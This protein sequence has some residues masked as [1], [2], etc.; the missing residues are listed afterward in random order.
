MLFLSIRNSMTNKITDVGEFIPLAAKHTYSGETQFKTTGDTPPANEPPK[1]VTLK[2]VWPEPNWLDL[3]S[4]GLDKDT[5]AQIYS[6]YHSLAKKPHKTERYSFSG[7]RITNEMWE[8]AFIEAVVFIREGCE[9]ATSS[10]DMADLLDTF[11]EHFTDDDGKRSYKTFAAGTKTAKTFLHPLGKSGSA[12]QYRK[13]LPYLD[14]PE[15]VNPKKIK[16][17]PIKLIDRTTKEETYSLCKV[18]KKS[19]SYGSTCGEYQNEF[20]SYQDA[21]NALVRYHGEEF[22][23]GSI[24]PDVPDEPLYIPKKPLSDLIPVDDTNEDVDP[25]TLMEQFGFRGI[26]FGNCLSGIEKQQFVNNT[27]FSLSVM[28]DVLDISDRWIGGGKLG[29]AFASRGRGNASAHYEPALHVINL[30]R[31]NGPGCIAHEFWHSLDQRLA[32]KWLGFEEVLLSAT[33]SDLYFSPARIPDQ[34]RVQFNAFLEIMEAC[35]NGEFAQNAKN[36]SA[37]KNSR[38]Y[39]E[40]PEELLARGFEAYVQDTLIDWGIKEQ[41]LAFGTQEDDY[42]DNG[43]HPYPV[44]EERAK[45]KEAFSKNLKILFNR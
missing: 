25:I 6:V 3:F 4:D 33:V 27:H 45:I 14:F 35:C 21:V 13:L 24:D 41:W 16:L 19:V 38:K 44:G 32:L 2:T 20:T 26:Q 40:L 31:F 7:V 1:A 30:T 22:T 37:Q 28:A 42:I 9:N 36:I 12:A 8:S 17:F 5:L 18:N 23:I 43:K 29:M 34:Y 39:W 10:K 11:T 15:R